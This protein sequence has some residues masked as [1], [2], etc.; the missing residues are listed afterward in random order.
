MVQYSA[1]SICF[2]KHLHFVKYS[3]SEKESN[4]LVVELGA[5]HFDDIHGL[6]CLHQ[7]FPSYIQID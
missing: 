1:D 2:Q 4:T 3:L 5:V 7:A 6:V